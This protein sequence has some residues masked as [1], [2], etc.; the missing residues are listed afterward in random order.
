VFTSSVEATHRLHLLLRALRCLPDAV[1]E[2]SSLLPPP[3]RAASLEA[4]RSGKAKVGGNRGV[5]EGRG[6]ARGACGQ[7]LQAGCAGQEGRGG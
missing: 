2:F 6:G 7:G 4:F 5:R 3:Q 1:V